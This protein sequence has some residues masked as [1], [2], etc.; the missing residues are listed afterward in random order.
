MVTSQEIGVRVGQQAGQHQDQQRSLDRQL[1]QHL[2]QPALGQ[3]LR[4]RPVLEQAT[5][6]VGI[7]A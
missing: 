3:Q 4:V 5:Q 6:P 7:T 2:Q 1:L